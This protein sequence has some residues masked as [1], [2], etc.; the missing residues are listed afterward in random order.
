MLFAAKIGKG[1]G[2]NKWAQVKDH[3]SWRDR[4]QSDM[5]QKFS[6]PLTTSQ[7]FP[8]PRHGQVELLPVLGHRTAGDVV[9]ALLQYLL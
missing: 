3:H 5:M 4:Y 2:G 7:L 6:C 1:R 8:Q 9:A